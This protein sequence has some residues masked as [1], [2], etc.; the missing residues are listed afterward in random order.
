MHGEKYRRKN[1]R[2]ERKICYKL[3]RLPYCI[4]LIQ[5]RFIIVR[6]LVSYTI[7][8]RQI[9]SIKGKTVGIRHI[10]A[11]AVIGDQ[12]CKI[13]LFCI[14]GWEGA[15]SR[16]IR[17]SESLPEYI[18]N[19]YSAGSLLDVPVFIQQPDRLVHGYICGTS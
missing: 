10:P 14:S 12:R 19:L 3:R 7:Q 1:F 17:K 13:P 16:V 18:S 6:H 5:Y 8:V 15:A 11:V 2:S 4:V 9:L